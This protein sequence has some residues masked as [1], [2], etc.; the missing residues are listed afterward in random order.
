MEVEPLTKRALAICEQGLGRNHF[1]TR[2]CHKN[3]AFLLQTIGRD[4]EAK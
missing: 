2:I 4:A 1:N 3:N